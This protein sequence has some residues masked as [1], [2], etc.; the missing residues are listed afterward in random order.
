MDAQLH[1]L[2]LQMLRQT[3][4]GLTAA[5]RAPIGEIET[6][7]ETAE[8][9]QD[10]MELT[11]KRLG[12]IRDIVQQGYPSPD[13]LTSLWQASDDEQEFQMQASSSSAASGSGMRFRVTEVVVYEL[14]A[15]SGQAALQE[16][17]AD[18]TRDRRVVAV[19][20]RYVEPILPSR[21]DLELD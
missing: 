10:R 7:G 5:I 2:I 14:A 19:T 6:G 21:P 3:A 8:R 1:T 12:C 11:I 16:I 13:Q 4:D 18:P 17:I 9:F 15:L 20:D